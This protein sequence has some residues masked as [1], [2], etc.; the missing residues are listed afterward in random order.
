MRLLILKCS[1]RK[2][3]SAELMPAL[4]RY[5]G[6][7]WHVLRTYLRDE[8]GL[9]ATGLDIYGLSAEFGLIPASRPIPLYNRTMSP[10]RAAELHRQVL[11]Q[12]QDLMAMG[13]RDICLGLSHRY[14]AA[15][16]GWEQYVPKEARVTITDGG[17]GAKL[18][19]LRAWLRG[20]PWDTGDRRPDRLAAPE[21]PRGKAE[22]KGSVIALTAPEVMAHARC[23]LVQHPDGADRYREWHVLVDGRPVSA[24]WLVSILSGLPTSAFDAA[25][26]RRV[27]LALGVDVERSPTARTHKR[28]AGAAKALA[29]P[30]GRQSTVDGSER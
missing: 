12:F 19:Q 8:H 3:G 10:E 18:G 5:D 16:V 23:A 2:R 1:A 25:A 26:A 4:E 11:S 22:L 7:L 9:W 20:E 29:A 24:K 30:E 14:F 21:P 13:Y 27:L 17:V 6:P 15:L 28:P